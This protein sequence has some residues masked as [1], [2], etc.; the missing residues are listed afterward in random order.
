MNTNELFFDSIA[1]KWDGM[2]NHNNTK[3]KTVL[4]SLKIKDNDSILDIGTGTG[5]LIPFLL[6]M[7]G[8]SGRITAIDISTQMLEIAKSKYN[9]R[10]V[11]FM[12]LDFM[13]AELQET[14]DIVLCYSCFPHLGDSRNAISR[15][16]KV[17]KKGGRLLIFHSESREKINRLHGNMDSP[18]KRDSLP[19]AEELKRIIDTEGGKVIY[20]EDS[21]EKY[22]VTVTL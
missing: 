21:E 7:L 6:D 9:S 8:E 1:H 17:L 22:V 2:V 12:K 4:E 3:I 18:V 13:E 10:Q 11:V 20:L 16:L 14:F 5:V 19:S 15:M